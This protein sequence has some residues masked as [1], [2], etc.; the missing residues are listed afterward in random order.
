MITEPTVVDLEPNPG[1]FLASVLAGLSRPRKSLPTAF[2]YDARG[3]ALFD[4]ICTLPE[5][6]PTRTELGIMR[7]GAHEIARLIGPRAEIIEYGSGSS[8][9]TRELLRS[10][11]VPVAYVPVDISREPLLR[12]AS[13]V[14]RSFPEIEV[15]PVCADFTQ[16]FPVPTPSRV[17]LRRVLYFPGSTIGNFSRAQAVRLLR[18]MRDEVGPGGGILIGVDLLK[19][20]EI[21]ERAYNDARGV[22]AAF[23]LNLLVRI[24]R[25]LG[26]NFEVEAFE[27]R[28]VWVPDRGAI[29]MRLVSREAQTVHISGHRFTFAPGEWIH[30]EDSHK[31]SLAGFAEMA[32]CAELEVDRTWIDASRLFSVQLLGCPA[33]RPSTEAS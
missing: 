18:Q 21:L 22:T 4:E 27:H 15:L 16:P 3:S 31:Y 10:L 5:Y 17:P 26:G 12:A 11:A 30:T 6:Y 29:E 8:L 23:N 20:V 33:A 28:A 2:L 1:H 24:N 13:A 32:R 19:P 7:S 9:K 25:E 14:A